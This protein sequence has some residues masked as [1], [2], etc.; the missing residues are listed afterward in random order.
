MLKIDIDSKTLENDL[1]ILNIIIVITGNYFGQSEANPNPININSYI[2][3]NDIDDDSDDY[4]DDYNDYNENGYDDNYSKNGY[5]NSY[6]EN[7]SDNGNSDVKEM[8]FLKQ[9]HDIEDGE[10]IDDNTSMKLA[11]N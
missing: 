3:D 5:Y 4:N 9:N 10:E 7:N 2:D 1:A 6:Y 8:C 11:V